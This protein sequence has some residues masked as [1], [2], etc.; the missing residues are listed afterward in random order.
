MMRTHRTRSGVTLVELMAYLGIF[1]VVMLFLGPLL[2]DGLHLSETTTRITRA[3]RSARSALDSI[4][5]DIRCAEA[6]ELPSGPVPLI[7]RFEDGTATAYAIRDRTITRIRI[8][9]GSTL[10]ADDAPPDKWA[11]T[12]AAG[13]F[14]ALKVERVPNAARLYRIDLTARIRRT[15]P[16][17]DQFETTTFTTAVQHRREGPE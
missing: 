5:R 3:A 17:T 2:S 1:F 15:A 8:P 10:S 14:T 6:V 16:D 4:R 11:Q 12:L 7:T 13:D 9:A